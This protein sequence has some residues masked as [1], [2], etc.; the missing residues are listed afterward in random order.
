MKEEELQTPK[1]DLNLCTS[2]RNIPPLDKV[3]IC[4]LTDCPFGLTIVLSNKIL[5]FFNFF[6]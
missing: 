2:D 4:A 5:Y 6:S 3:F 1:I